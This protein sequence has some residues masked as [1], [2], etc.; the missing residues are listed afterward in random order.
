MINLALAY[1]D[2]RLGVMQCVGDPSDAEIAKIIPKMVDRPHQWERITAEDAASIRAA[3]PK[4]VRSEPPVA[5]SHHQPAHNGAAINDIREWLAMFA[6]GIEQRDAAFAELVARV[7]EIQ[8]TL[9]FVVA[10]AMAQVDMVKD[11]G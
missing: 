7:G 11:D 9:D 4:A 3:R 10:N 6:Q 5:E 2:G 8:V 1:S